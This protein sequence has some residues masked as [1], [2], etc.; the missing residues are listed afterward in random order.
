MTDPTH[1]LF[2]QRFPLRRIGNPERGATHVFV[3]YRGHMTLRIPI[4]DERRILS[5][6]QRGNIFGPNS[7]GHERE[8][9]P[10]VWQARTTA[11]PLSA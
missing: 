4:A 7:D 9:V 5:V 10:A 8:T 2:G 11:T 3:A 1:P 6:V